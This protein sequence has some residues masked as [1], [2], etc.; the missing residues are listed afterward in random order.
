[1]VLRVLKR[2]TSFCRNSFVM[3]ETQSCLINL[4]FEEQSLSLAGVLQVN[5]GGQATLQLFLS[6]A[7]H[8]DFKFSVM[9]SLSQ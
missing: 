9:L 1:M 8:T 3:Y 4:A 2:N 7:F 5:P 6:Q